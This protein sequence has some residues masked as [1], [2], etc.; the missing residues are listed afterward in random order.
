MGT[1][2]EHKGTLL[3]GVL[4]GA[5]LSLAVSAMTVDRIPDTVPRS[6]IERQDT[7]LHLESDL[8]FA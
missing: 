1:L 2:L 5:A 4:V 8:R 7:P 3:L 6:S